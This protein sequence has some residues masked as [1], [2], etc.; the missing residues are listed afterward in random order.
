MYVNLREE[1]E[2]KFTAYVAYVVTVTTW[3]FIYKRQGTEEE[4]GGGSYNHFN[5]VFNC[6][7][8]LANKYTCI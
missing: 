4:G 6:T 7:D 3:S 1:K 2:T 8:S 5:M